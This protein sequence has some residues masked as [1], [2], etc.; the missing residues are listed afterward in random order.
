[1][2]PEPKRV[3]LDQPALYR[4]EVQG[5]LDPQWSVHFDGMDLS[6]DG[7]AGGLFVTRLYG[8]VADQASLHGMLNHIRDLG[9]PLLSVQMV[10]PFEQ[11]ITGKEHHHA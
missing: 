9:L 1:M 5:Q 4:I 7:E 2:T 6:T 8:K 3:R 10:R 11:E